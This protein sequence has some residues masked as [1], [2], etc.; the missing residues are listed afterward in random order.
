MVYNF[1][2]INATTT[3]SN[4]TCEL[5]QFKLIEGT[6]KLPKLCF[7]LSLAVLL[8]LFIHY[9]II[10]WFKDWK[11][12]DYISDALPGFAFAMSIYLVII[13]FLFTFQLSDVEIARLSKLLLWIFIPLIIIRLAWMF[14]GYIPMDYFGRND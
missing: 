6:A 14:K 2:F 12:Y 8:T 9:T 11:H 3:L 10:P 7:Y 1:T 13:L 5:N 4:T